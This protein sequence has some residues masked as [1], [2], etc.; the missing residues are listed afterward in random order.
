MINYQD[1]VL[2][3]STIIFMVI[4][5]LVYDNYQ[6]CV[7]WRMAIEEAIATGLGDNTVSLSVYLFV[8]VTLYMAIFMPWPERST[9]G[10]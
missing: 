2:C 1:S 7:L 9:G 10:I 3:I 8:C 5:R 6:D 4:C